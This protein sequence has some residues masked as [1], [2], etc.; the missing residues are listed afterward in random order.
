MVA[1]R[2]RVLAVLVLVFIACPA[3]G[4]PGTG[5]AGSPQPDIGALVKQVEQLQK[6]L[7]SVAPSAQSVQEISA[8]HLTFSNA[9]PTPKTGVTS[10]RLP[11]GRHSLTFIDLVPGWSYQINWHRVS[12][13][14][15]IIQSPQPQA[16]AQECARLIEKVDALWDSRDERAVAAARRELE[17]E[18]ATTTCSASDPVRS[19]ATAAISATRWSKTIDLTLSEGDA[20][21]ITLA[22]EGEQAEILVIAPEPSRYFG[23][24]GFLF[25]REGDDR[26]FTRERDDGR[27][28]IVAEVDRSDWHAGGL[29]TFNWTMGRRGGSRQASWGLSAG[30]GFDGNEPSVLL[31]LHGMVGPVGL[32]VGVAMREETRLKGRYQAFVDE[33]DPGTLL[34]SALDGDQ[35]VD[36]TF[37]PSLV[38][39]VSIRF[40]GGVSWP[41]GTSSSATEG[42]TATGSK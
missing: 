10:I 12:N 29:G 26:F 3:L 28:E 18:L 35:L 5:A 42:S 2:P 39:G 16:M 21:Q 36:E 30:V 41:G 27:F 24:A 9:R 15:V 25:F 20:V 6:D 17:S 37:E 23:S 33:N 7:K 40:S 19:A 8:A 4:Q 34:E 38:L 22:R 11:E 32:V 1:T 13:A 31:G 14:D